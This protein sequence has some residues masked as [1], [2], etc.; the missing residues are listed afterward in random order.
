MKPLL[1]AA[2]KQLVGKPVSPLKRGLLKFS[3]GRVW[4]V[5][6]S[7]LGTLVLGSPG[8]GKSTMSKTLQ[9]AFLRRRFGGLVCVVKK[10]AGIEFIETAKIAGREKDVVTLGGKSPHKLNVFEAVPHPTDMAAMIGEVCDMV[11][12]AQSQKTGGA[13][14]S[15]WITQRDMLLHHTGI[16]ARD[17]FGIFDAQTLKNLVDSLPHNRA[18]F[19]DPVWR[20]RS[21]LWRA[22]LHQEKLIPS[23]ERAAAVAYLTI[24]FPALPEKTQ[25]S[26]RSMVSG[27]LHYLCQSS[28]AE[29]FGGKSTIKI[30]EVLNHRKLLVVDMPALDS[31]HGKIANL[32]VMFCFC[33]GARSIDR[34]TDAFL[35]VDE[36]QELPCRE[37]MQSLAVLRDRRVS[38]VL[39]T[40]NLGTLNA[41]LGKQHGENL[42]E[43]METIVALGQSHAD[44]REWICRHIG[45]EWKWRDTHTTSGGKRSTTRTREEVEKVSATKFAELDVGESIVSFKKDHWRAKWPAGERRG[46]IPIRVGA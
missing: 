23:R 2:N 12:A 19:I 21:V 30:S 34:Y 10:S 38:T 14:D 17:V 39:L 33:K 41:G 44:T 8:R 27:A 1:I 43:L 32:L 45:K 35:M 22:V 24:E 6:D 40:Q 31:L 36:C 9:M 28:I 16:L 26:V 18:E 5:G 42:C 29:V 15:Y 4:T 37:L 46:K 3:E 13:I 20:E 25:G 11:H 7:H